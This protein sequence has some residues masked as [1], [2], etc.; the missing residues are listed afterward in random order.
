M[1]LTLRLL[2][3]AYSREDRHVSRRDTNFVDHCDRTSVRDRDPAR[4]SEEKKTAKARPKLSTK[5]RVKSFAFRGTSF[6]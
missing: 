2:L 6:P 5:L 4:Y 3:R 1:A